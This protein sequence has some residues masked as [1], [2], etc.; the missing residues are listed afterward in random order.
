[1][2]EHFRQGAV[3]VVRGSDRLNADHAETLRPLVDSA[4]R[5]GQPKLIIDLVNVALIDSDGLDFLLDTRDLC[6]RRGGECKL[7]GAGPLCR[8]ILRVSGVDDEI[9]V[10]PDIVAAAGSFAR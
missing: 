10:L 1:M 2:A 8:D 4:L 5:H 9:E 6:L 7:A 3:D